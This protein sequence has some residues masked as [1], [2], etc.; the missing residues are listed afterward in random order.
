MIDWRW[1]EV[2]TLENKGEWNEA[3]SLLINNWNQNPDD[4]KTVIRLGFFCWYVLT[5]E[6]PV[7]IQDVDFDELETILRQV[8]DFGLVNW[9]INEDFLWCFGYMIS[10]FP[11]YFGEFEYWEEKGISMLKRA[12]EICPD[13]P[14]YKYSYLGSFPRSDEKLKDEFQK[15]HVVLEDRF[16]GN[17]VLSEY[18]KSVWNCWHES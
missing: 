2:D 17:G 13:E 16:Q 5:E 4:L 3:K 8:T 12:Y 1:A 10:L 7:E 14:V 15:V 18:F 6:G 11:Y 9:G